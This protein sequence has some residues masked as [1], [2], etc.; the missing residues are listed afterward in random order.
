[1]NGQQGCTEKTG[2]DAGGDDQI[3]LLLQQRLSGP[4]QT[5]LKDANPGKGNAFEKLSKAQIRLLTSIKTSSAR[6]T[7]DSNPWARDRATLS[8]CA[9]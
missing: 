9:A 1:M 2:G 5:G 7:S 8:V 3:R 4:R 6:V